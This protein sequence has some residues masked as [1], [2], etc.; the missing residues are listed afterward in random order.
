MEQLARL[1]YA[2][3][4]AAYS[5]IGLLA[6]RYRRINTG[7]IS[8]CAKVLKGTGSILAREGLVGR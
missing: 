4:G 1:G 6:A 5:L 7:R 2:T 8:S 3:E